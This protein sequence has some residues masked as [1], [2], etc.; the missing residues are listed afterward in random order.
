MITDGIDTSTALKSQEK[1]IERLTG[2]E[3]GKGIK[4]KVIEEDGERERE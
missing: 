2:I 3:G 4:R 1:D